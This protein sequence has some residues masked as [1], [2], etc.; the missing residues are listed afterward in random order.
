MIVAFIIAAILI[1]FHDI[2][3]SLR[4]RRWQ[5]LK[6]IAIIMGFAAYLGITPLLK[7][8]TPINWV[9]QLLGP[10]GKMIFK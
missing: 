9:W 10:I 8:S 4:K 6:I 5:E 2:L 1:L 7:I 3:P